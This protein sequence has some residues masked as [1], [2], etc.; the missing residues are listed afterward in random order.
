V[1]DDTDTEAFGGDVGGPGP[2]AWATGIA[3]L[4]AALMRE[5]HVLAE[6]AAALH[7]AA[8]PTPGEPS[9]G[10]MSDVRRQR[11]VLQAGGE[12]ALRAA[13][14]LE[15]A[16]VLAITADPGEQAT[17]IAAAARRTGAASAQM[18]TLLRAAALDFR[19]DDAAARIA[20][21]AIAQDIAARLERA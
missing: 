8:A 21:T 14:A 13:L 15:A 7:A 17:R 1:S 18:A 20:A 11:A 10:P 5:A 2:E 4:A 6:T 9:G 19:S 3:A 12:A 16:D